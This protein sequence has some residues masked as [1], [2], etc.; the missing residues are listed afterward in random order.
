MALERV[1]EA[2]PELV[3][4]L[5]Q[6]WSP[7]AF[8]PEHVLAPADL[9]VLFEA[10]RWSPSAGNSQPWSFLYGLRGDAAHARIFAFLDDGNQ[11]W[12]RRA[13]AIVMT[14]RQLEAGPDH[15]LFGADHSQFDL[16]QAA[17]HFSVQAHATG[18]HVHQ[19][20]GFDR[21]GLAAAF[22]VPAHWEVTSGIAVG[23]IAPPEI[24][25]EQWEIDRERAPRDRRPIGEFVFHGD[26]GAPADLG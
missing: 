3:P 20:S 8:D 2:R 10:A 11:R 26:W 5:E 22:G 6:R 18:L 16:G 15:E 21:P 4:V 7:R 1:P 17:A 25:D 14:V 19:F 12:A 9:R 13:S 23:R 24:F